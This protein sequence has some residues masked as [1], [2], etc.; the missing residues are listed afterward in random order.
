MK[1]ELMLKID[2]PGF[3]VGTIIKK[4]GTSAWIVDK[5]NEIYTIPVNPTDIGKFYI[6]LPDEVKV[7][8][9]DSINIKEQFV[10]KYKGVSSRTMLIVVANERLSKTI[11]VN[12]NNQIIDVD[13]KHFKITEMYYFVDSKGKIQ[14]TLVGAD[15][16]TDNYR[17]LIGNYFLTK[18]D[19]YQY[20][21]K[22]VKK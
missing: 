20:E 4:V 11:K 6:E 7:N 1:T 13:K 3:P 17:K 16:P 2:L 21:I 18:D 10:K 15:I 8:I 22:F 19:V 5:T 14:K 9:G 12:F